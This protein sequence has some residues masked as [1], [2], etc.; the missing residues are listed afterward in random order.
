MGVRRH[1]PKMA[2]FATVRHLCSGL[3]P[4]FSAQMRVSAT[5][6]P[7]LDN[8]LRFNACLYAMLVRDACTCYLLRLIRRELLHGVAAHLSRS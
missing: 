8:S 1:H 2:A 7:T 3:Q 6:A 5:R 4:P